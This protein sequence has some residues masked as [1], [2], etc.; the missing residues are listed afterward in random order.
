MTVLHDSNAFKANAATALHDASLQEALAIAREHSIPTRARAIERLPEFERLR[1]SGR[2]LKNHVI[3]HLDQYLLQFEQSVVARGGHVHWCPD[4]GSARARVLEICRS[5]DARTVTKG[6]SMI[7]EE[8]G[9]NAFL[10]ANGI[11]PIET[12]L[13]EYI[14]QLRRE[15][16]SHIIGPAL[17]VT[18]AQVEE[19]FRKSHDGLDPARNLDDPA[20]LMAEAR[21]HLREGFLKADVG[22]TGANFLIADEGASVIVT[23]EG[24]GDLTQTLPR[25][26]IVLASIEKVVPDMHDAMTLLRLLPRSGTG[27]ELA[28][29][30]TFSAGPRRAADLDGPGE[31]HVILLDNGRSAYLGTEFEE[32]LRCIRCGACLDHC[33]V[34]HSVGGHAYGWVY[35]GPIGSLL[36]PALNGIENAKPLPHASTLCGRCESVCPMRIPIP[37][38]LRHWRE[39]EFAGAIAPMPERRLIRLWA[40]FA[41]RPWLYRL[42]ARLAARGLHLLARGQGRLKSA[43][44]A[45]GWTRHRDLPAPQGRTFQEQ[46]RARS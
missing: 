45:A 5:V 40:F 21:A 42:A 11:E 14:I 17:H 10:E 8:I 16:P 44:F 4:A 1:N 12:D 35:S 15:T 38:M 30:V 39:R 9:I 7:G 32:M 41:R 36:N 6:K 27:Q 25:I 2:D 46:W 34:Y 24:N 33:P 26:H 23:N 37:K 29:Y 20:A 28:V 43:P 3:A 18:Q 19:T 31:Y 22:I 13:G